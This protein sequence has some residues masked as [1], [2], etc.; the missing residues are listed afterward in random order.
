MS[1]L[2]STVTP[3]VHLPV[4][5][6]QEVMTVWAAYTRAMRSDPNPDSPF[7]SPRAA[8]ADSELIWDLAGMMVGAG[9]ESSDS[10]SSTKRTSA[11]GGMVEAAQGGGSGR[12]HT[13]STVMGVRDSPLAVTAAAAGATAAGVLQAGEQAGLELA[14]PR[15]KGWLFRGRNLFR[16]GAFSAGGS[17]D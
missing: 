2:C 16:A 3:A 12:R 14:G 5:T 13:C 6:L 17:K 15:R 4:L 10:S 8:G 7:A 9:G 1:Q 11:T